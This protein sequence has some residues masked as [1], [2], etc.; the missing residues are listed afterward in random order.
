MATCTGAPCVALCVCRTV[1]GQERGC[2]MKQ[3]AERRSWTLMN[4]QM[5]LASHLF[6]QHPDKHQPGAWLGRQRSLVLS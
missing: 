3:V 1:Y 4:G 2:G 6:T 5:C